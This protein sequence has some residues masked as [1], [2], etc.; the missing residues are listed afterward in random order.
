MLY[1]NFFTS[2]TSVLGPIHTK[3][4]DNKIKRYCNKKINRQFSS[5][6]FFPVLIENNYFW[7]IMLIETKF[8]NILK[9]HYNILE[10]KIHW[11]IFLSKCLFIFL[12]Q[13]CVQKYRKWRGP[14][15]LVFEHSIW[16]TLMSQFLAVLV[17]VKAKF[18]TALSVL[19]VPKSM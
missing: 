2:L 1:H 8:E 7:T 18:K 4:W 9:G 11:S 6:I 15:L 19:R 3:Y 13:Y 16:V 17:P 10:K 12:S 5:N 14:Y